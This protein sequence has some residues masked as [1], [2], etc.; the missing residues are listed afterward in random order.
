MDI[1]NLNKES[2][3]DLIKSGI[4]KMLEQYERKVKDC[5]VL[6][7]SLKEKIRGY[8]AAKSLDFVNE[9]LSTRSTI[10]ARRQA[11]VQA[12]VDIESLLD[13]L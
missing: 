7:N 13:H 4:E 10:N 8:R 9:C 11:Y 6:L 1:K 3:M 2:K 5:D 12:A